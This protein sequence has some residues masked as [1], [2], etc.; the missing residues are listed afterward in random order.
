M[1]LENWISLH[2]RHQMVYSQQNYSIPQTDNK[3]QSYNEPENIYFRQNYNGII[4]S[5]AN[6][7]QMGNEHRGLIMDH[8]HRATPIIFF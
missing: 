1:S 3:R 4:N 8:G 6:D 2:Q 5:C 7:Q